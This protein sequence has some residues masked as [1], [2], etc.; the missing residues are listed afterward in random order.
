MEKQEQ[1]NIILGSSL[2]FIVVKSIASLP[3]KL[4]IIFLQND[5]IKSAI[6]TFV[7]VETLWVITVA[8][9]IILLYRYIRKSN[10]ITLLDLLANENIRLTT[11]V[12][13]SIEGVINLA[14]L[15]PAHIVNI[16]T[17]LKVFGASGDIYSGMIT[18]VII[19]NIV[20]VTL[21]LCQIFLGIYLAKLYKKKRGKYAI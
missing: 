4:S 15:L 2:L 21:V 5:E 11:G 3:G 6:T 17:M 9:I 13:L 12:L 8:T 19:I 1:I 18:K 20:S 16:K 10:Q 14:Q 7:K